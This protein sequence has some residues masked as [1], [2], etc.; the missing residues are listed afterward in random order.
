MINANSVIAVYIT[1]SGRN[2][3]PYTGVTSAL[4]NRVRQ[5][6]S[7]AFPGFSAK[8]GCT[9]LVWYEPHTNMPAAIAKEK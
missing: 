1:A 5:H 3:T 9:L 8:Y 7:K 6:E 2:G 4:Q